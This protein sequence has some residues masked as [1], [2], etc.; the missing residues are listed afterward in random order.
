MLLEHRLHAVL[1]CTTVRAVGPLEGGEAGDI[2]IVVDR[3]DGAQE[4]VAVEQG[5]SALAGLRADLKRNFSL[6]G[7]HH[8]G[9]ETDVRHLVA[10]LDVSFLIF[11]DGPQSTR[12]RSRF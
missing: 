8:W 3:E 4:I 10:A 1:G 5:M 11:A 2:A 9:M 12:R 6:L 7:N